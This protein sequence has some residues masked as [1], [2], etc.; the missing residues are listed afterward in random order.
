MNQEDM[1]LDGVGDVCD[2][3]QMCKGDFDFDSDVDGTDAAVFKFHFGRSTFINPCPPDGPAPVEKTHQTT[4]YATGDDG[5]HQRGVPFPEPRFVDNEDGTVRDNL[6]GLI[7]LKNANCF[8]TRTWNQALSDCNGLAD[9]E[10][11]LADGSNAGDWR[12]PQIKELL[13]LIDFDNSI[14]ALPSGHPFLNVQPSFYWSSTTR[15][16]NTVSAWLAHMV[17]GHVIDDSKSENNDYLWP[18]RGGH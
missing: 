12:L 5:E 18:V 14:P 3:V 2:D 1:D 4:S 7:W 17:D 8:G 11:E 6:T 16:S 15:V 9:G 13:S 10:C